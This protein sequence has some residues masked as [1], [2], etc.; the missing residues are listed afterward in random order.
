MPDGR[1]SVG[2]G[3]VPALV[4]PLEDRR[5]EL[6]AEPVQLG[7]ELARPGGVEAA[8]R[9]GLERTERLE[10]PVQAPR[11]GIEQA[12]LAALDRHVLVTGELDLEARARKG[13]VV[14]LPVEPVQRPPVPPERRLASG[15]PQEPGALVVDRRL[16]LEPPGRPAR[17]EPLA[18][19]ERTVLEPLRLFPRDAVDRACDQ[20]PV[21]RVHLPVDALAEERRHLRE[22]L[23][24]VAVMADR[25]SPLWS[26]RGGSLG[27][28]GD[29]GIPR[30]P[31]TNP[32]TKLSTTSTTSA[33]SSLLLTE[34]KTKSTSSD[35]LLRIRNRRM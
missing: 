24:P 35:R 1:D 17:A 30:R 23:P 27:G 2:R 7:A 19:R 21:D 33:S 8:V 4:E 29:A 3:A 28:G 26:S 25:Q 14:M 6:V 34:K 5:V 11:L 20:D 9:L 16:E 10:V 31:I 13:G 12:H 22:S 32:A 15:L 18:R